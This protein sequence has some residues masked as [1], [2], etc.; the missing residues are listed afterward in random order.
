MIYRVH[1]KKK[2]PPFVINGLHMENDFL[3]FSAK[4]E[5]IRYVRGEV[6]Y[7]ALDSAVTLDRNEWEYVRTEKIQEE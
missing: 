7:T 1:L 2:N 3:D 5:E 6:A 4:D